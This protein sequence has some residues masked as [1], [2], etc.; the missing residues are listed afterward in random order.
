MQ[1]AQCSVAFAEVLY[2]YRRWLEVE[3]EKGENKLGFSSR[4]MTHTFR[5]LFLLPVGCRFVPSSSPSRVPFQSH[6]GHLQGYI[7]PSTNYCW[8]DKGQS[9]IVLVDEADQ[10]DVSSFTVGFEAHS[11]LGWLWSLESIPH[12]QSVVKGACPRSLSEPPIL[13]I[14]TIWFSFAHNTNPPAP[15][16]TKTR[17]ALP[18]PRATRS[19]T[20]EIFHPIWPG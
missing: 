4:D 10:A 13:P 20:T 14:W 18:E 17:A 16:Q 3:G 6:R 1:H 7:V 2:T 15:I 19:S 8:V 11:P 12:G 5:R 9:A